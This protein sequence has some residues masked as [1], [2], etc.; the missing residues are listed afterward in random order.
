MIVWGGSTGLGARE[1]T[2]GRYDPMHDTW[3]SVPVTSATAEARENHVAIWTGSEMIVWGGRGPTGSFVSSGGRFDPQFDVWRSVS[4]ANV[5]SARIDHTAVWTG[6]EMVIWGGVH[7]AGGTTGS[8]ARYAPATNSWSPTSLSGA[9]TPRGAHTALWIGNEMLV[10]GGGGSGLLVADGG[11]YDP[12][13]DVWR[14]VTETATVSARARH[15]AVWTGYEMILWGGSEGAATYPI[16]GGGY[17]PVGEVW[18]PTAVDAQTP[19]GRLY[20][21][22]VWTGTE[23]IVWGGNRASSMG[24]YCGCAPTTWYRDADGDGFGGSETIDDACTPPLGYV[25]TA[26]DCDDDDALAYP[27]A[28]ELCDLRDNDCD[29]MIDEGAAASCDDG[30]LCT[31]D[32]C[33]SGSCRY[34]LVACEDGSV[35]TDDTCDPTSGCW[36]DVNG[37]CDHSPLGQGY[38]RRICDKPHGSG[39]FLTPFDAV[40]VSQSR[41]FSDLRDTAAICARLTPDPPSDKCAQAEAQFLTL[42]LNLCRHRVESTDRI[43]SACGAGGMI[44]DSV[45]EIDTILSSAAR[46]HESCA[47]AQCLAD[48]INSGTALETD[49]LRL[50]KHGTG[51]RLTWTAPYTPDR[52]DP[53]LYRVFRRRPGEASFVIVAET[54]ERFVELEDDSADAEFDVGFVW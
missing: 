54:G 35:C 24:R 10:W 52:G 26:G 17:D 34:D 30:T 14:P 48:E 16:A 50:S 19:E 13:E 21:T 43:R 1:R 4:T 45:A 36:F 12:T 31:I 27:H 38:F 42:Q 23:M 22:A 11:L 15:T 39:E 8:G 49:S 47:L 37:T 18:R 32:R 5:P 6:S 41:S 29:G 53:R 40:C 44:V 46:D 20:H 9:P 7:A 33:E 2:G 28:P 3:R 25:A 51:I